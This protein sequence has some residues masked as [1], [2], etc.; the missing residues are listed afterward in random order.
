MQAK[1]ESHPL[2]M[3][4]CEHKKKI[5]SKRFETYTN[6]HRARQT[7]SPPN[8]SCSASRA[9][10]HSYSLCFVLTTA[11]SP[12]PSGL[13]VCARLPVHIR[14]ISSSSMK[15]RLL[16]ILTSA[17]FCKTGRSS[18]YLRSA[19]IR[20]WASPALWKSVGDGF[21]MVPRVMLDKKPA[22]S[23]MERMPKFCF[24]CSTDTCW[25]LA[26]KAFCTRAQRS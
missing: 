22:R 1:P 23:R 5:S 19:H 21:S 3:E 10:N 25:C 17:M 14:R 18:R 13:T 26:R 6:L 9:S 24:V 8:F 16:G 7:S 4:P 15:T 2:T 20:R 12:I 11:I